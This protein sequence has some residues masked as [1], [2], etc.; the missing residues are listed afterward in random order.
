MK[1]RN[2]IKSRKDKKGRRT[3][4]IGGMFNTFTKGIKSLRNKIRGKKENVIEVNGTITNTVIPGNV[5]SIMSHD[6]NKI[7]RYK[8]GS[9]KYIYHDELQVQKK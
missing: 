7:I 1:T 5:N 2:K 6:K 9:F 4:K 8:N 3:R